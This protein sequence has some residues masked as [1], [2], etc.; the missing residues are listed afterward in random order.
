MLQIENLAIGSGRLSAMDL[1][2]CAGQAVADA[3]EESRGI[4]HPRSAIILCG[5]GN[6]GGD[7]YAVANYLH[8]K[9][10]NIRVFA[11]G[12]SKKHDSAANQMRERWLQKGTYLP[13]ED[14]SE[15]YIA[16]AIVVDAL[17]GI[18]LNREIK[19]S[20]AKALQIAMQ[21]SSIVAVDILSGVNA[22]TGKF[23][24]SGIDSPQSAMSTVTFECPKRGHFIGE[25]QRLTGQLKIASLGLKLE[26]Q[27]LKTSTEITR[28]WTQSEYPVNELA[29]QPEQHKFNHGHAYVVAGAASKGGAARLA[30][31]A[32]LRVGAGL[33]T[34]AAPNSALSEHAAQLNA[35]MLTETDTSQQLLS[36]L[37]DKRIN[38]ICIGPGLGLTKDAKAKVLSVLEVSRNTVLDADALT[39]FANKTPTLFERLNSNVVLTPHFGE[40][41]KL[42]PEEAK[43]IIVENGKGAIE[44][45]HTATKLS[46][47]VIVLKGAVT[48]IADPTGQVWISAAIGI[49]AV[50]WLATAGS[51]DVLAG[52]I[53]GLMARGMEPAVAARVGVGLHTSAARKFG[54][55]L[56][57]EDLPDL[58]PSVLEEI[59]NEQSFPKESV[60]VRDFSSRTF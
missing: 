39:L 4:N 32:A 17:F 50:P 31:K 55:G 21:H 42:F 41:K 9:G 59:M 60:R 15:K 30:A 51:G 18:G 22:D 24:V 35:I 5:T 56:I 54:V 49:D 20:A 28:L 45:I 36:K 7:G 58:I 3:V 43:K 10:W 44:A 37:N 52:L 19:G 48:M 12:F 57:S 29:K 47:A 40:F 11:L 34:I 25:G 2:E 26:R 16:N 1:M 8:Q 46:N 14:F 6:N 23:V 53:T 33:V 13:I 38:A 27:Q